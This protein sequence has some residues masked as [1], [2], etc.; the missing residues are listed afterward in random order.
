MPVEKI[1]LYNIEI[2]PVFTPEILAAIKAGKNRRLKAKVWDYLHRD[3]SR[4]KLGKEAAFF[5]QPSS[6]RYKRGG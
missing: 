2:E 3:T 5:R 6:A 1:P 4:A